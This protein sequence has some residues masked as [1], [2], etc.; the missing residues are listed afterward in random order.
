MT[1]TLLSNVYSTQGMLREMSDLC[2]D[3]AKIFNSKSPNPNTEFSRQ[4]WRISGAIKMELKDYDSAISY[5]QQSQW[6][7]EDESA[8]DKGYFTVLTLLG[9]CF[10]QKKDFA[11]AKLYID[12]AE[13]IHSVHIGNITDSDFVDSYSLLNYKGL[14]LQA[15]GN[16]PA[17][18]YC[19]QSIITANPNDI[20]LQSIKDIA[21]NNLANLYILEGNYDEA[22]SLFNSIKATTPEMQYINAQNIAMC[23]LMKSDY[24]TAIDNLI[25]YNDAGFN[26]LQSI[27]F[28]FAEVEREHYW[29]AISDQMMRFNNLLAMQTNNE[30]A[31]RIGFEINSFVRD[32]NFNFNQIIKEECLE[33]ELPQRRIIWEEYQSSRGR[34][35]YGFESIEQHDSIALEVIK[36]ERQILSESGFV[37]KNY[38]EDNYDLRKI[39]TSLTADDIVIDFIYSA[40]LKG[41]SITDGFE[42]G[43]SVYSF[44]QDHNYPRLTY[45]CK[46]RD[47]VPLIYSQDADELFI[48]NIY[49]EKNDSIY[50][51]LIEPI[52]PIISGKKKIYLRPIGCLSSINIEAITMPDGRRFGETYQVEIVSNVFNIKTEQIFECVDVA[53]FGDP[54]FYNHQSHSTV[55][56][57]IPPSEEYSLMV[58]EQRGNWGLLPGTKVEIERIS[59]LA[60][61]C[62]IRNVKYLG[63]EAS[64]TTVKALSGKS[65]SVIHFATHGYFIASNETAVHN[66]FLQQTTGY[67]WGNHLM[68]YSGLLFS[69]ANDV[70]NGN[71]KPNPVDDG[72]LT[73]DEISRLDFSDTDLVVLSACD[74]GKGHQNGTDGTMGLQRAFKAA[75]AKT[76]VASLWQIPDEA[77]SL[78][79]QYFYKYLFS[80]HSIRDSLRLAQEDLRSIGYREP[81]YWA[82][83]LVID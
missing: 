32:F 57:A 76:M 82:S 8:Y 47:I 16:L 29:R 39:S 19:F 80:K 71:A 6:M 83:F 24:G 25:T 65:P 70:W 56:L 14:L 11:T 73:A 37:I 60:S 44:S 50:K 13:E 48:N 77:T 61:S 34:L 55:D 10:L 31:L 66:N 27:V 49:T 38:F 17:A 42:E 64:E 12:E 43:F 2:A 30:D 41:E 46:Q 4:L 23:T 7:Y 81:Y 45:V 67:S 53:L 75:G 52:L 58:S 72:V 62:S 35:S 9:G 63:K 36:T 5:L 59:E 68:L 51:L 18:E 28:D 78:L 26:Y 74:T 15:L 79:M 20:L 54:D 40:I 1:F 69:G 22:I 3:A 33:R 21:R